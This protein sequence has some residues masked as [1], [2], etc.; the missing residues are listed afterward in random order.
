[1]DLKGQEFQN[2]LLVF[3]T[4][5]MLDRSEPYHADMYT[6]QSYHTPNILN[7]AYM[8]VSYEKPSNKT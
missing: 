1:M 7:I 6:F 2:K 5:H 4:I 3:P 8:N